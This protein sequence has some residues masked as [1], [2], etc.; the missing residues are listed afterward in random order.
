M[1]VLEDQLKKEN[2]KVA[3][4][5]KNLTP[6]EIVSLSEDLNKKLNKVAGHFISDKIQKLEIGVDDKTKF[7]AVAD[8][9]AE[10]SSL[11]LLGYVRTEHGD[12]LI[13]GKPWN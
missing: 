6:H 8:R 13:A 11:K 12:I 5:N 10:T 9:P 4:N 3:E 1:C 2:S 7:Y